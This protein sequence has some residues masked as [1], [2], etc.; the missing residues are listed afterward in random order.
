MGLLDLIALNFEDVHGQFSY[1]E[2]NLVSVKHVHILLM[3]V[4]ELNSFLLFRCMEFKS[5]SLGLV[6]ML[7]VLLW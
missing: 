5:A 6:C 3:S 7:C 1:S 4:E 2:H